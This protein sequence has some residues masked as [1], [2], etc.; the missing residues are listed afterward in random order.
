MPNLRSFAS[1]SPA[2]S[3]TTTSII[4]FIIITGPLTKKFARGTEFYTDFRSERKS[5]S[6]GNWKLIEP[7]RRGVTLIKGRI[8]ATVV[9]A[10]ALF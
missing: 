5:A 1:P 7:Q 8:V 2:T 9:V 10:V 4:N 3:A 6:Y